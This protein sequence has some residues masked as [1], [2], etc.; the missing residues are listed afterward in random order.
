MA[1]YLL[2]FIVSDLENASNAG[3]KLPTDTL[4]RV[5]VRP[6]SVE[7]AKYAVE[8]SEKVLKALASYLNVPYTLNKCDSAGVPLK[9]G[10]MENW[11]MITY[12]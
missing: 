12:R 4:H 3:T 11:G 10:A 1:S 2:A 6:D 7:K 9:S 8:N 5:W